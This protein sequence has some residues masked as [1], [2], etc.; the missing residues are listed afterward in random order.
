MKIP[1]KTFVAEVP[2]MAMGDI[3]FLLLI[4]FV[5]LAKAVDDS[6]VKWTPAEADD[7]EASGGMRASVAIDADAVMFL[8]GREIQPANLSDALT[9]LLGDLEPGNRTVQLKV[10]NEAQA[11]DFEP[12]I[13]AISMA[14]GDLI[15]VLDPLPEE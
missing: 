10:H 14:G 7:L 8:N 3:A 2:A 1:R 11:K 9:Q 15:H 13:E 5:I 4:F 6:H 12:A